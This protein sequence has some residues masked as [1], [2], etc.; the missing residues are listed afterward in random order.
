MATQNEFFLDY[1]ESF[2]FRRIEVDKIPT[3]E[4]LTYL[5]EFK[6]VINLNIDNS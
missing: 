4:L 3:T 5:S 6:K 2:L 1:Y